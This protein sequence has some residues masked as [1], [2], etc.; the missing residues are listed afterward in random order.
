MVKRKVPVTQFLSHEK[1]QEW[2]SLH[3]R[4][5]FK[6]LLVLPKFFGLCLQKSFFLLDIFLNFLHKPMWDHE[7]ALKLEVMVTVHTKA[8]GDDWTR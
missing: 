3:N 1:Y 6:L 2:L 8:E 5:H 4:R 7:D